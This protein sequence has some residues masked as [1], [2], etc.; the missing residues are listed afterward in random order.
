MTSLLL[1]VA[2]AILLVLSVPI[3]ISLSV[4][5]AIPMQFEMG[6]KL[7]VIAQKFFTA[8][9]SYSLMAIPLF[10]VAGGLMEKG[11]VSKRLVSFATSLVGW[12]PG[13]LAVVAFVASAFFGAI[14]GSSTA[15][16]A[17]IGS[18][19]VPAML[20]DGYPLN[21]S[22]ATV[23]C[24]G[25][26][27]VIIPPSIPM[28]LYG[29]STGTSIGELFLGGVIPGILLCCCMGAYSIFWGI[30]HKDT[31]VKHPFS[32]RN[33]GT[34]LKDSIWALLMPI[35]VLGG[36]YAGVF[37]PTESAAISILYGAVIGFFGY[38]ELTVKDSVQILKNSVLTTGMIMF[39]VAGAALFGYVMTYENIPVTVANF[40]TG[41]ASS[42]LIFSLLVMVLLLIVGTF[43]DTPPAILILSP[44]LYPILATYGIDPV[45]FGVM[46]VINLGIGLTTPPVGMN[47]YVAAGIRKAGISDV[48]NKHLLAYIGCALFGLTIIVIFPQ[49]VTFLP[50]LALK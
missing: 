9:D 22:L 35:V 11:G 28:V 20:D 15:T 18:I 38:K 6:V 8:I 42:R 37:T 5:A 40:I 13:G 49:L 7:I 47:L 1:F 48:V 31:L 16:V 10:I 43:M 30:K 3:A 19:V 27:G 36:I 2:F 41:I 44:I 25:W 50:N 45:A 24:A 12:V 32:W 26:L 34:S 17:A 21:F 4:A 14:S 46:M 29:V 39:V 33:V 23:A